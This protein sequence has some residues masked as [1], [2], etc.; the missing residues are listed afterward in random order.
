MIRQLVIT[1]VLASTV[2]AG[3]TFGQDAVQNAFTRSYKYEMSQNYEDAIKAILV[4]EKQ[5]YL[6]HLRLGWLYYLRGNYANSR[7]HYQKAVAA[8]PQ[9]IE[10]RLGYMLPLLAQA[11]YTEVEVVARQ[12]L[13][14][15]A[16]NYYASL[17]LAVSLRMQGKLAQAANVSGSMLA[18]YPTDIKFLTELGLVHLARKDHANTRLAFRKILTLDPEN[19]I[20][21]RHLSISLAG[22]Y[23]RGYSVVPGSGS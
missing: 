16:N 11:R 4:L 5:D 15:D 12:V 6:V 23:P 8:A 18:R 20:A 21:K 10:P 22:K 14:V 1:C 7:H 19:V 9:A 3:T 2:L 17:R 13:T